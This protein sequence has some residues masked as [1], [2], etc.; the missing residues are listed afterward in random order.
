[1][2]FS[3]LSS[4]FPNIIQDIKGHQCEW[5]R[6]K[7][8][9]FSHKSPFVW[10][11]VFLWLWQLTVENLCRL[12]PLH[13]GLSAA[14]LKDLQWADVT[15]SGFCQCWMMTLTQL[16]PAHR[17]LLYSALQE[18]MML[19]LATDCVDSWCLIESWNNWNFNYSYILI[20]SFLVVYEYLLY[21]YIAI[22]PRDLLDQNFITYQVKMFCI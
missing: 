22:T 18:V 8:V 19:L 20:I 16:K 6:L 5:T 4:G 10:L 21:I 9:L 11:P 12:R 3:T 2:N 13:P 1:M 15:Q 14:V 17:A 7:Y